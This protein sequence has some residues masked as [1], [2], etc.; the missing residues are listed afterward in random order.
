MLPAAWIVLDGPSSRS[1]LS[2]GRTGAFK[3]RS[4]P[5]QRSELHAKVEKILPD[6]AR[7]YRAPRRSGSVGRYDRITSA[8]PRLPDFHSLTIG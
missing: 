4:Q 3:Q 5:V 8:V 6:D 1:S 7:L 2:H